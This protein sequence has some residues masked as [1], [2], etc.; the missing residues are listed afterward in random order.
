MRGFRFLGG[1]IKHVSHFGQQRNQ[2]GN[3]E[4][5]RQL[6]TKK[7]ESEVRLKKKDR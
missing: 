4:R 6:S 7:G 3:N 2:A 5:V 1:V